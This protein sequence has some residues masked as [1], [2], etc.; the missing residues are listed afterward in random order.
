MSYGQ[1]PAG[2]ENDP[3]WI[4]GWSAQHP[5]KGAEVP[6]EGSLFPGHIDQV[7]IAATYLWGSDAEVYRAS[8]LVRANAPLTDTTSGIRVLPKTARIPVRAGVLALTLP[9][10]DGPTLAKP[11]SYSVWEVMPGGRRFVISVPSG[12]GDTVQKLHALEVDESYQ[13]IPVPRLNSRTYKWMN[14]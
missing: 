9:A 10:S 4:P 7:K 1:P 11:F 5:I 12:V 6:P 14:W 8:I 13:Q 3:W 2:F